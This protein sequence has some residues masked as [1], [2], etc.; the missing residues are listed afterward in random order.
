MFFTKG[1]VGSEQPDENP[2]DGN[3]ADG[4]PEDPDIVII[5]PPNVTDEA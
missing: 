5:E 2:E 1:G 3:P 4:N